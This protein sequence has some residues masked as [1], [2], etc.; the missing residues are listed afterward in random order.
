MPRELMFVSGDIHV[1]A[2]FDIE[3]SEPKCRIVSLTS[4]GISTVTVPKPTVG[5]TLDE[6]FTVAAGIRSTL[7]DVVTTF[8]FGVVQVMPKGDGA[9]IV[10]LLAHEGTAWALGLDIADLL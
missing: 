1:G 10:P 4:S 3:I 6:D 8:N 2:I 9:A 5:A 7:R